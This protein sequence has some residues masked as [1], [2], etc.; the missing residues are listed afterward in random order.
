MKGS[1][2]VIQSNICHNTICERDNN[3]RKFDQLRIGILQGGFHG[4]VN[5]TLNVRTG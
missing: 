1:F 4:R 3:T 2:T 5:I